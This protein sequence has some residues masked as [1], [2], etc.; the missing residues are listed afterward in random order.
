[1]DVAPQELRAREVVCLAGSAVLLVLPIGF[2]IGLVS[3]MVNVV[4]PVAVIVLLRKDREA[5]T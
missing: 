4:L 3:V 1:M 2:N 5:F